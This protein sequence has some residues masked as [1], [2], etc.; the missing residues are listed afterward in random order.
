[1]MKMDV[2]KLKLTGGQENMYS[3]EQV[4]PNT[5]M[6]N[7]TGLF[8]F[9]QEVNIQ[10]LV[11][12][13]NYCIRDNDSNRI[14]L[15]LNEDNTP[16]Q[17][18]ADYVE[19]NFN[20]S[21]FENTDQVFEFAQK[22]ADTPIF[23]YNEKLYTVNVFTLPENRGGFIFNFHHL[24]SDAWTIQLLIDRALCHY[25]TLIGSDEEIPELPNYSYMDY[26]SSYEEYLKSNKYIKDKE[27]WKNTYS[28]L[29]A[30]ITLPVSLSNNTNFL[31]CAA[32]RK[33]FNFSKKDM[34]E[35]RNYCDTNK[36]TLYSF[37]LAIHSLYLS[38]INNIYDFVIGTPVLNR[39]NVKEKNTSGLFIDTIPFSI[40]VDTNSNF[41]DLATKIT[42]DTMTC[43][44]HQKYP[45][46]HILKDIKETRENTESLYNILYSYQR[47]RS[48]EKIGNVKYTATWFQP[49]AIFNDLQ[50]HI[51][52]ISDSRLLSLSYDYKVSRF[53]EKM[54]TDMFSR[55]KNLINQ[56]VS[57]P[58]GTKL[59]DYEVVT[60]NEKQK[61]LY[62]F[63][64]TNLEYDK[65]QTIHSLIEKQVKE[66]PDKI[67]I[68][69]KDKKITYKEL[70]YKANQIAHYLREAGV[71]RNS[72]VGVLCNR[73]IEMFISLLGILKSGA[74]YLPI[75]PEYPS[76]RIS[77]ML[78]NSETQIV[79]SKP[80]FFDLIPEN[81]T[82]VNVTLEEGNSIY[83]Y[84]TSNPKKINSSEDLAYIIYTSGSTG[85]P[86]G[87]KLKH[88]N[89]NNFILG[90]T[91]KINFSQD[92]TIV[93]VT[94]VCFD[95]F[96]LE[97]YLPLQHGLT[98]VLADEKEQND[99]KLLNELCLKHNVNI[100]QTTP[101]RLNKLSN[102]SLH[103][104]YFENLTDVLVGG[105]PLPLPLLENLKKLSKK[106]NIY[107]MY[108]PTE[109]AVWSTIKDLS[110]TSNITIGSPIANTT[111]YVLDEKTMKLMPIGCPGLLFIGGDGVCAGYH[112]RDDLNSKLFVKNPYNENEIIYNT[113]D[114]V[115]QLP[116]G[117][118]V[119]LGRADFQV[120]IRGYRIELGEIENKILSYEN[121]KETVIVSH[122]SQFLIC[123]YSAS[124]D[125]IISDLI[126]YLLE[127]LPNYMIPAYFIKLDHLPL[128]PN[129]KIDRKKLPKPNIDK[130]E[131]LE[132]AKTD[133][134]KL[135][136]ENILKLLNN[137]MEHVDINTPFIS[138]GLDSLS[139]IQLQSMLLGYKLIL[140]TQTFYKFSNIKKLAAYIDKSES[141]HNEIAL[142]LDPSFLHSE[143]EK[144][145]KT[146]DDSDLGNVFLTGANGFI[147]IHILKE[148]LDT[149]KSKIYCLVRG[150]DVQTSISRL[151]KAYK[152]YFNLPINKYLNRRVF[153]INGD[154]TENN[155]NLSNQ[156]ETLLKNNTNTVIH[157]AAIVKHYGNFE[158]F[159]QI[160]I[161]G[162][163]NIADFAMKHNLRFIHL[164]SIS[165]SGNY[166]LKQDN[167]DIDFSENN[168]YIGQHYTE[169]VY[170][171]S[172]L[173]AENVIYSY[174]KKGLRGKVLRIGIIAGRY[175]DGFFQ[176]NISANAFYSR[177][178]SLATLKIVS[179][180]M[181]TQKLE[182][183]PIDECAKA[184]VL[185]AKT[186]QYDNKI[187]HLYNPNLV[188]VVD[189]LNAFKK[190]KINVETL[191]NSE[192][193]NKILEYTK[194]INTDVAA[195][196]ND[197]DTN[198]LSLNYNFT[199]N[200][201]S[202][203]S[204]KILKGLG[205]K[206][207]TI[208]NTYLYKI[209][210][211][212]LDVGFIK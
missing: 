200:I 131:V 35:I 178:K 122:E 44:R 83:T 121:I 176:E 50:I 56:I 91:D 51:H 42:T 81:I 66:N 193:Q 49:N 211:H 78:E 127:S 179:E 33:T 156:D 32:T 7:V 46:Q 29:Q 150:S 22:I 168:F 71:E 195:I 118:F 74:A 48:D 182:F 134:E 166:L 209:I 141:V 5:P 146:T 31:D 136:E 85:K 115:K 169:N 59:S 186:K 139:I 86:K 57:S 102:D 128:T 55:V 184:I 23:D 93:S 94:T 152:Y 137:G 77:Y 161:N 164:S 39:T 17:Y 19:E 69:C 28:T 205:F 53:S 26:T 151:Q 126:S 165:I 208:N 174:M 82:K 212:M 167:R 104:K 160:N 125:V 124:K 106:L 133:S 27:F 154:I 4:Y 61:L 177:I 123:Y 68:I 34:N 88:K 58:I 16:F 101:S 36:I 98:I 207:K 120:K 60:D 95:I 181:L 185:L 119:H 99:I 89:I 25:L 117:E 170:V 79:L 113:N 199:V 8:V 54:I 84:P 96:V 149:T 188:S 70:N 107:N 12:A 189:V 45:Y 157:T 147:G 87:V 13:L 143:D 18:L 92:K 158:E 159:K 41:I 14:R 63:N 105:E 9:D 1:M 110:K 43:F 197:F 202:D 130:E 191:K 6:N 173:E 203:F 62:D 138:L 142:S 180:S 163:K 80:D 3:I 171:N 172:K 192:F 132:L 140:T 153:V 38:R 187:F 108:G 201:K 148:L 144:A 11:K 37:F 206:W 111:T 67:A 198:N 116:N 175:S 155:L 129:G 109:T 162:T 47:P 196:V 90:T 97:S 24:I 40:S 52:D 20:M 145:E 135:L 194:S 64:Q 73:S 2:K 75:D 190:Y 72:F 76:D 100:I 112:K 15:G 204:N 21:H 210:K 183:T 30:P 65:T 103:C 10:A 114:L